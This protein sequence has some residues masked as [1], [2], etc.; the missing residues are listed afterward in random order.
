MKGVLG[1]EQEGGP[2]GLILERHTK[3]EHNVEF[4]AKVFGWRCL[5]WIF[6]QSN[7]ERN[8]I[9]SAEEVCQMAA[10]QDEFGS[11][12]VT[13]VV[14]M[15]TDG[16]VHF[17]AFQVPPPFPSLSP[18]SSHTPKHTRTQDLEIFYT[19][20]ANLSLLRR[21]PMISSSCIHTIWD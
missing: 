10:V 3:E 1:P 5:G 12:A 19:L 16:D 11:D 18:L 21:D 14:S 20:I 2:E 13:G 6:A 8:Y 17:E 9:L 4:L 15:S 7:K